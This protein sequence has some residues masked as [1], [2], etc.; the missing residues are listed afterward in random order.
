MLSLKKHRVNQSRKGKF[1]ALMLA[2]NTHGT[3]VTIYEIGVTA[4]LAAPYAFTLHHYNNRLNFTDFRQSA[5]L[6]ITIMTDSPAFGHYVAILANRDLI[7]SCLPKNRDED[8]PTSNE[9]ACHA[10][11]KRDKKKVKGAHI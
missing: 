10:T 3:P 11:V 2:L 4:A 1:L 8:G 7:I 5:N 9:M 6:W